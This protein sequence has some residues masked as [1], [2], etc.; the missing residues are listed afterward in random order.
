MSETTDLN[1][2]VDLNGVELHKGDTVS[3]LNGG[4]TAKVCDIAFE[5]DETAFVRLRPL[6]SPFSRGIWHAAEHVQRVAAARR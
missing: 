4:T 1:K 5:P 6:H 2:A 3:T